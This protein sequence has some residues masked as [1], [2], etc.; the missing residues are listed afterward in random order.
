MT[1]KGQPS[2]RFAGYSRPNYTPVPDQLFDEQLPDLSGAELK[3]L[4]Y[5]MRR[6]FG[7]KKE[8]DNVSLNQLLHGITTRAGVQLDRGTGLSRSTLIDALK[9][10]VEKGHI[11]AEQ[12]SSRERGNE[13][14]NY[15]LNIIPFTPGTETERGA[16]GNRTGLVGKADPQETAGQET[17]GHH[18]D[19]LAY[20]S[21]ERNPTPPVEE[22]NRVSRGRGGMVAVAALVDRERKRLHAPS[23]AAHASQFEAAIQEITE[24]FHD[25]DHL[26]S[27]LRQ[28]RR[29]LQETGTSEMAF[30]VRLYEARAI[31]RQQAL[32][33]GRGSSP[34]KKVPYMFAVLRD[35][36]G[37]REEKAMGEQGA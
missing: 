20:A 37:L 4:L 13:A 24:E 30:L 21:E 32:H 28:A 22:P 27:N 31:T 15:R 29:L 19:S 5:L 9:G 8:S 6:I 33:P 7:F 16:S 34:R 35:L 14:T 12:R 2:R 36:L 10:L 25:T 17:D 23:V 1:T 11:I 26:R 3:V 18:R